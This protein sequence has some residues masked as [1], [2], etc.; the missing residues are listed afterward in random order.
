MSFHMLSVGHLAG[1]D[2]ILRKQYQH[3]SPFHLINNITLLF[4]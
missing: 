3:V 2:I 4:Q 1:V